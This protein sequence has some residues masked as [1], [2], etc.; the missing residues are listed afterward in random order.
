M[1]HDDLSDLSEAPSTL[2]GRTVR[3][4]VYD[5]PRQAYSILRWG[6]A[7]LFV[8]AGADKFVHL[9]A[10]WEAYL[11][12]TA[13]NLISQSGLSATTF[14]QI[15]G[16]L[17]ILG[18]LFMAW[19]PRFSAYVMAAWLVI[20]AMNLFAGGFYDMAFRNIGLAVGAVALGRLSERYNYYY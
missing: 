9:I 6:F 17:E 11:P 13:I 15:I 8:I 10:N 2:V 3:E 4:N 14:M 7:A 5:Y 1:T 18:G 20:I 12:S 16:G 19:R